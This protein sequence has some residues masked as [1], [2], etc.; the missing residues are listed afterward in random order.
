[1]IQ[2]RDAQQV[3]APSREATDPA[4]QRPSLVNEEVVSG[5]D[6]STHGFLF[7]DL[8]GYTHL[9]DTRGAVEASRLLTRY[10]A[11]VREVVTRHGGA[12]IKTEGDSFYVVLPSASAALRCGLDILK[13][14]QEPADGGEAIKL[15]IGIHAGESVA[16]E[17]GFVGSAINIAARI[18]A[19]AS[20]GE[21]LVTGTIREL[22]R[23]I[24]PA[25]FVFVGRRQLKGLDQPVE[26]FRVVPE[27]AGTSARRWP[28]ASA[29]G[30][31]PW[32]IA[33]VV[34]VALV[35]TGATIAFGWRPVAWLGGNGATAGT[36]ASSGPSGS[37]P[38]V[39]ARL[40][41]EG[42]PV[43]PGTYAPNRNR[44]VTSVTI[45]ERGWDV[46]SDWEDLLLFGHAGAPGTGSAIGV[47][48]GHITV[49]YTGG[50]GSDPTR[51]IGDRPQDLIDW[52]Q[53]TPQLDASEP[54]SVVDLGRSGIG[55]EA[56]VL[57]PP[58]DKCPYQFYRSGRAYFD[59]TFLWGVGG[60]SWNPIVGTHILFE[61]LDDGPR[62]ITVVFVA[63]DAAALS[64]VQDV[65]RSILKSIVLRG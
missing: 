61:A 49:V 5:S 40:P 22:T 51:V 52:V 25:E 59:N 54:R 47:G 35:G 50:C 19:L 37:Q 56:T 63:A 43:D 42:S 45:P 44:D 4:F 39:L 27:G 34:L 33:A 38:S 31:L 1:V 20:A 48:I 30:A 7:S 23:S 29:R 14:C 10:Q 21:I 16:H 6:G 36:S 58:A 24:V 53:S 65:G 12:E 3:G 55:I 57:A 17:G 64:Y 13:A 8:R 15:G 60:T 11:I 28:A 46:T 18:C 9:V 41:N 62:T 26:V 2:R 32:L